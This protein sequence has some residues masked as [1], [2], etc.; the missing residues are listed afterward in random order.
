MSTCRGETIASLQDSGIASV[1]AA[2]DDCK[3][4]ALG[5]WAATSPSL[6]G[7][8]RQHFPLFSSLLAS[9]MGSGYSAA[10][11]RRKLEL[12]LL[13]DCFMLLVGNASIPV[14]SDTKHTFLRV[15]KPPLV[16]ALHIV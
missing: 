11:L 3:G 13:Q 7:Y 1:V 5:D 10:S 16:A 14:M 6:L 9:H 12:V 8:L 15:C 4:F 2:N